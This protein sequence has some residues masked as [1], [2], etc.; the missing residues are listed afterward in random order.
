[1]VSR[2]PIDYSTRM[3]RKV[4]LLKSSHDDIISTVVDF[5]NQA[6]QHRL[7]DMLKI[8]PY[9]VSFIYS[10]LATLCTFLSTLIQQ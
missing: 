5:F 3:G 2:I 7:A 8:K 10:I 1:M 9:L 4:H 6:L